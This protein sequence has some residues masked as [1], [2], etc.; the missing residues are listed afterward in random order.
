[1][2]NIINRR[3]FLKKL[4]IGTTLTGLAIAGCKNAEKATGIT[5]DVKE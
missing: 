2:S 5:P 1:M 3:E 4:G